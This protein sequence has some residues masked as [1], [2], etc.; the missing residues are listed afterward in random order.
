MRMFA[1]H[2]KRGDPIFMKLCILFRMTEG[3]F[4]AGSI[5]PKSVSQC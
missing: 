3:F 2:F 4:E 1:V 5:Y